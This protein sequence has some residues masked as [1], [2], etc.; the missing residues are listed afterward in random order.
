MKQH[1]TKSVQVIISLLL[2]TPFLLY[3]AVTPSHAETPPSIALVYDTSVH[4][5]RVTV[6]PSVAA[7]VALYYKDDADNLFAV[8]G[9]NGE[10][11]P[12]ETCDGEDCVADVVTRGIVKV[13]IPSLRT[14]DIIKFRM[15]N[16]QIV[17][18]DQKHSDNSDSSGAGPSSNPL[19]FLNTEDKA[20]LDNPGEPTVTPTPTSA[21]TL[22]P[23]DTPIPSP[24]TSST[25]TP[26]ETPVPT[27][28]PTS[29]PTATL[30]PSPTNTPVPTNTPTPTVTPSPTVTPTP[31]PGLPNCTTGGGWVNQ[32]IS[33]QQGKQ[34]NGLSLPFSR[35]DTTF[36]YGSSDALFYS[37]GLGGTVTYKFPGYV[38]QTDGFDLAIFETTYGSRDLYPEER[39]QIQVSQ[40]GNTWKIVPATAS[41]R[42]DILGVSRLDFAA[43]GLP[44]IQYVRLTDLP[45]PANPYPESDGFDTNAVFGKQQVCSRPAAAS[46]IIE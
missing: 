38:T 17:I 45:N 22:T 40:D 1:I 35:S 39:A 2:I 36:A 25:P 3:S 27:I 16:N 41:S 18:V 9:Q 19:L 42:A 10:D 43:S 31:T 7:Q 46:D 20:W 23:T 21:S 33:A 37:L 28:T 8:F 13:A 30:T 44:W 14:L 4:A 29:T 6:T 12:A 34:K 24:S 26:T 11:L 5:F 32:T 15:M